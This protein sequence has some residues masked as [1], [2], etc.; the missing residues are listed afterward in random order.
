MLSWTLLSCLLVGAAA[1]Y[2]YGWLPQN[3]TRSYEVEGRT[4]AAIHQ[5]SNKFTGVLLKA[6]LELY[7]PDATVIRGQLKTPVYAQINRDLSGGWSEQIPDLS[8]NWNKLPVTGSPFEVHLNY[9]TGQV[10]R[11]IVNVAVELWEV[12]MIKG[13]L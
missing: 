4:L 12:N 11:L 5:V 10:E 1:A 9:T 8:V 7:R 3:D 2:P 13:I 6:T